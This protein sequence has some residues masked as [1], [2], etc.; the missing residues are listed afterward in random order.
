MEDRQNV[1]RNYHYRHDF[2]GFWTVIWA[3]WWRFRLL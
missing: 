1:G 2:H 3:V